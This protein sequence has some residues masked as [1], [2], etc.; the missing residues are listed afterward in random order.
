MGKLQHCQETRNL[1]NHIET[2]MEG[3]EFKCKLCEKKCKTRAM[4]KMHVFKY[5]KNKKPEGLDD[6]EKVL[7]HSFLE[8][9]QIDKEFPNTK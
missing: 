1:K 2:H 6:I 9:K 7:L 5:H 3:L 4:L 8:T